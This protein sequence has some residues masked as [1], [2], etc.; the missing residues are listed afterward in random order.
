MKNKY[1]LNVSQSRKLISTI[2]I[3]LI[4]KVFSVK[5]INYDDGVIKSIDGITFEDNKVILER[6]IYDIENDYRK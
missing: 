4:F 5:D 2:F 3:G 1:N 6:D